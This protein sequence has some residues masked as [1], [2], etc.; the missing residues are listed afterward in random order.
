ML[1]NFDKKVSISHA[2]FYAEN[3]QINAISWKKL[4][5]FE[6]IGLQVIRVVMKALA[7]KEY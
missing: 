4:E 3:E 7:I 5:T 6:H 2:T 1:V